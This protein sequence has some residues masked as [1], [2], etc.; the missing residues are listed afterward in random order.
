LALDALSRIKA[1]PE[2]EGHGLAVAGLAVGYKKTWNS[3]DT[4][5]PKPVINPP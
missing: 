1:N 4:L 3:V 5:P 2:L